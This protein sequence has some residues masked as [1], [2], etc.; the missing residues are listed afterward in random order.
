MNII[1]INYILFYIVNLFNLFN[2]SWIIT[3]TVIF[4]RDCNNL[5]SDI[6]IL[7]YFSLIYGYLIICS[8]MNNNSRKD[9]IEKH[10]IKV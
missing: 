8:Y 3:G 2:F 7:M 10:Y 5:P 6:N 4:A 1:Y 9:E